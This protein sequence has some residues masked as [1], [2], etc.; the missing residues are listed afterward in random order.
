MCWHN[1]GDYDQSISDFTEALKIDPNFAGAYYNRAGT[2][3]YKGDFRRALADVDKALEI[4][5]EDE[6]FQ[7]FKEYLE[8]QIR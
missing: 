1:K 7:R 8:E 6:N 2:W 5:P 3:S 4:D